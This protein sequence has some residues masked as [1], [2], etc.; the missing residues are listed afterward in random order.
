MCLEAFAVA[1]AAGAVGG[2]CDR[3]FNR[4]RINRD[5]FDPFRNSGRGVDPALFRRGIEPTMNIHRCTCCPCDRHH[6]ECC[7][8]CCD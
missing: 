7:R 4:D 1:A 2:S 3:R 5:R 8:P 6:H